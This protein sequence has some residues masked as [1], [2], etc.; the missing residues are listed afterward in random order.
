V[1]VLRALVTTV[2]VV[3][4]LAGG[5]VMVLAK[6]GVDL[7][8][9]LSS[10]KISAWMD[11]T[12]H[13]AKQMAGSTVHRL[14]SWFRKSEEHGH[15]Q[16]PK[17]VVT[18][19]RVMDVDISTPYVC[20]I[21]AQQHIEIQA[22]DTGYIEK[23]KIQEGQAIK[24]GELMFALRPI[25]YEAKWKA[26]KAEAMLA[27]RE[28]ENTEFLYKRP[29]PVVSDKE[30]LL[31]EA[32]KDH[33]QAKADLAKAELEFTKVVAPFDGIVD[34][35]ERQLGS[36]IK[37]GETLTT[38]SDNSLMWV[39]F[40]LTEAQYLEYMASVKQ[41]KRDLEIELEL[42]NHSIFLDEN[43]HPQHP[44]LVTVTGQFDNRT[45]T[46]PF[47]ADFPNPERLL[48]HG[49]TGTIWIHRGLHDALVIPQRAV[50]D[51]LDKRYV[52]VLDKEDKARQRLIKVQY[53]KD[54]IFVVDSKLE[55]KE[56]KILSGLAATDKIV[57]EGVREVEEGRKVEYEFRKPEDALKNQKYHAE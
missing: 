33:A 24:K 31:Y 16:P 14:E 49:Q 40:N 44:T 21:H 51:V 35:Q 19:P 29:R 27:Q 4:V 5:G 30:V 41:G 26:E 12:G 34:R 9:P 46:I 37:E 25:L 56:G 42:A 28:W 45:G 43:K 15:E 11:S 1:S 13:R 47:R 55:V 6:M 39:Y 22:V 36:L 2:L 3:L 18:S 54:D 20:Q 57:L 32:R 53:T 50:F 17:V 7:P 23:I 38:L 52:W 8:P 10:P 48:R